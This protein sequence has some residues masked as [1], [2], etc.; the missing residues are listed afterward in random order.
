MH[1]GYPGLAVLPLPRGATAHNCGGWGQPPCP[2]LRRVVR[3]I[4]V[5]R[6]SSVGRAGAIGTFP[7]PVVAARQL[8][9]QNHRRECRRHKRCAR[10]QPHRH[11]CI[12]QRLPEVAS[13]Q[14]SPTK[15]RRRH[16]NE[17]PLRTPIDRFHYGGSNV[18]RGANLLL[19]N[20][21]GAKNGICLNKQKLGRW[22]VSV[23][24]FS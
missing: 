12:L 9:R 15:P 14:V 13:W 4:V 23:A 20:P 8:R 5:C 11:L 7:C 6:G 10:Q 2:A 24:F 16:Q 3:E 22:L 21:E 19:C 1:L 17:W 18:A